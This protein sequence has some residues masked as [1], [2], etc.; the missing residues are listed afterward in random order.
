MGYRNCVSSLKRSTSIMR[1][2]PSQLFCPPFAVGKLFVA[3][4]EPFHLAIIQLNQWIELR[5]CG[6]VRS[7]CSTLQS[8]NLVV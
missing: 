1:G 6:N 5:V 2:L 3:I 8:D 7:G 4:P